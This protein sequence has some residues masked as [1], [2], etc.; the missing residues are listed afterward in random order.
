MIIKGPSQISANERKYLALLNAEC[1][2]IAGIVNSLRS[3]EVNNVHAIVYQTDQLIKRLHE[4]QRA[5]LYFKNRRDRQQP[6]TG[7]GGPPA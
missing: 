3:T 5:L 4:L 1:N 7:S 2:M 6:P